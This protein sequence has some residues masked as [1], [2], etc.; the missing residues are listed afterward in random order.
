MKLKDL[1]KIRSGVYTKTAFKGD[2][3]Y[4]QATDISNIE[5]QDEFLGAKVMGVDIGNQ[6]TLVDGDVLLIAKGLPNKAVV[7]KAGE[8]RAVASSS[9]LV[10]Y[11]VTD[12]IMPD[13]LTWYINTEP[14]QLEIMQMAIGTS[15]LSVSKASVGE[16]DIPVP[17]LEKQ[18]KVVEIAKLAK[19]EKVIREDLCALRDKSIQ[20]QLLKKLE[21]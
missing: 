21:K 1:V 3:L 11:H 18:S 14:V 5:N 13:Y 4:V 12:K 10:F 15:I 2:V 8:E 6:H 16:L 9:Y 7:F 19:R 17:S 20:Y